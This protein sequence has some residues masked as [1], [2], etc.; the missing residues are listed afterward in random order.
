MT[1]TATDAAGLDVEQAARTLA[2]LRKEIDALEAEEL[3]L[4]AEERPLL[5]FI[6]E[7]PQEAQTTQ[8]DTRVAIRWQETW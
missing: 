2:R 3:R 7:H 4:R 5:S 8:P 1:A 6:Q